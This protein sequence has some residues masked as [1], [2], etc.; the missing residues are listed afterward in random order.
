MGTNFPID[1]HAVVA[2]VE[3]H[4]AP[5]LLAVA[6]SAVAKPNIDTQ[7]TL[8]DAIK[9][10]RADVGRRL[11]EFI[12]DMDPTSFEWLVRRLFEK[13]GYKSVKVTKQRGDGGIDVTATLVANGVASIP[14]CIQVKRQKAAVG[15][16]TVQSLRGSLGPH[17]AGVLITSGRFS[18]EAIT[19]AHDK[20][21]VPITLIDGHRLVE[22][23]LE[24]QIGARH[25]PVRLHQLAVEDLTTDALRASVEEMDDNGE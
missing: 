7:K 20:A 13:L 18:D 2:A 12:G 17:E 22:L 16:P 11:R 19:E 5:R 21:K 3:K 24:H 25:I 14:T 9:Q 8:D 1:D 6:S 4:I 10:A 15:R 23:L